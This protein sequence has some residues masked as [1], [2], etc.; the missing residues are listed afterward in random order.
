[1]PKISFI[2]PTRHFS[3]TRPSMVEC[4]LY[5]ALRR[6]GSGPTS[7]F[8]STV[9]EFEN[10]GIESFFCISFPIREHPD[11]MSA[12]EGERVMEK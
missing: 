3:S 6:G 2:K 12:S 10:R 1:M 7:L 9:V 4:T 5:T 8:Q 11:M